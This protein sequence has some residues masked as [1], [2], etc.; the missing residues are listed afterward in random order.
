[1]ISLLKLRVLEAA[2]VIFFVKVL[3]YHFY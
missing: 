3:C 1:M 2:E